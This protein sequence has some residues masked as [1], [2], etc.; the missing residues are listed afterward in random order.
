M[1]YGKGVFMKTRNEDHTFAPSLLYGIPGCGYHAATHPCVVENYTLA[2]TSSFIRATRQQ[3]VA[4]RLLKAGRHSSVF[5][6]TIAFGAKNQSVDV[7]KHEGLTG[8][9]I[10]LLE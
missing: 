5:S 8:K 4:G 6:F 3:H 7:S 2:R 9:T 1:T 10:T